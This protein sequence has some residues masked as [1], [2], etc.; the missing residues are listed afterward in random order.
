MARVKLPY[1][2]SAD[3]QPGEVGQTLIGD[4]FSAIPNQFCSWTAHPYREVGLEL[5]VVG[6]H[7]EPGSTPMLSFTALRK[8]C[9]HPR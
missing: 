4:G 8:R 7:E 6:A 3:V 5:W 9:L 1:N 2:A